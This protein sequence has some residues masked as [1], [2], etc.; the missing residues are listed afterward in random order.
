MRLDRAHA[1]ELDR[2]DPLRH[3]RD[4]F[5][6][7][8]ADRGAEAVYLCGHSLGAQ[9]VRAT[10]LVDEVLRDWRTLGVEGHFEG[11]HPWTKYHGRLAPPLARLV[12]A[13]EHEVVA[14]N[15]LTVNLHLLLVSFYRPQGE[16]TALL[17]EK[18]S[19]PSDRYAVESQVR[20]HGL[21]PARDLVEL[22]PR[23]GEDTLRHED[24]L[25]AIDREG[26]RIATVLLP[27]VQ[28]L[29][30][31]RMDI[32]RITAAAHAKGCIAGFD[33]AHAIGN[34]ELDLHAA[35][36]D[37]AAWCSYKYLNGGPGAIAGAFVH[38]RHARRVDLPR[39][40]G[41]WGHDQATRFQMGP[42]FH[43][44]PG[45]EG[46][47]LSNPPILAMAPLVAAME[48]FDEAGMPSLR[49][50]SVAL[51]GYL[52]ALVHA[53]LAGRIRIVT[54]SDP[55]QRGAALSLRVEAPRDR[56]RAVF[57]GL[58]RRGILPDWR[59]PGLIRVAPV[60]FYNSY[61]DAW[62]LVEALDAEL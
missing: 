15:S 56:A 29:T 2:A 22:E 19:F 46:W 14:M 51:T 55:S 9:P 25:E 21:D 62:R 61:E 50:K 57:E 41:W 42:D 44:I 43:P 53:R 17:V 3:W 5:V 54:P 60:P 45:A 58:R 59:E 31:Q 47:Q 33:L 32:A 52:E 1:Q 10:E 23:P 35:G 4:R 30:G 6:L 49:R 16:R 36:A 20:F 40:A 48:H 24:I 18:H 12:G 7:P 27:G 11:R 37:F 38:E 39:F 34:V 8:F 13:L 28:Y 26:D